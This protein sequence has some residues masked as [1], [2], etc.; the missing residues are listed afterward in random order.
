M[1]DELRS[2]A[3]LPGVVQVATLPIRL[4]FV[5]CEAAHSMI[6]VDTGPAHGAA[7]LGLKLVVLFGAQRQSR[8]LPRGPQGT[9]VIGP[10]GPPIS[11]HVERISVEEVFHAWCALTEERV[12]VLL[13]APL[14]VVAPAERSPQRASALMS[15]T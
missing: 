7:A 13:P 2:A 11:S 3:R 1:L 5:L 12:P 4:F 15:G 10:G 9:R 14:R 8:W 6:S